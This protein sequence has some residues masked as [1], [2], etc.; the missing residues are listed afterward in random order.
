M[1]RITSGVSDSH[2]GPGR[3]PREGVI[4][5]RAH[6]VGRWFVIAFLSFWLAGW[7]TGELFALRML[8]LPVPWLLPMPGPPAGSGFSFPSAGSLFILFWLAFWT[9]G[10]LS[11]LHEIAYLIGG[12]ETLQFR[13]A[14]V[15]YGLGIGP[16]N[17]ERVLTPQ[18]VRRV[19]LHRSGQKVVVELSRGELSL[20]R[21]GTAE[22]RAQ[23][24]RGLRRCLVPDADPTTGVLPAS[25]VSRHALSAVSPRNTLEPTQL[26]GQLVARDLEGGETSVNTRVGSRMA[27]AGC[28]GAFAIP[29][30]VGVIAVGAGNWSR[31]AEKL[32]LVP[33]LLIG[34]ALLALTLWFL[35]GREEWLLA[36][37]RLTITYRG[38]GLARIKNYPHGHLE[39]LVSTDSDGDETWSLL[40]WSGGASR[41]LQRGTASDLR[42]LGAFLAHRTG[43]ELKCAKD[44]G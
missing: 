18:T 25:A 30:N 5:L 10:G 35:V 4:V 2:L 42:E 34:L 3:E 19:S 26:P 39:V 6:G 40:L 28:V 36:P 37:G 29:W 38:L 21:F 16:W 32:F 43:W 22:E 24:C 17:R 1:T 44:A 7:A 11:A 14:E 9:I 20:A 8:G 13:P 23:I 15:R 12:R 33:H 41:V 31:P 27:G